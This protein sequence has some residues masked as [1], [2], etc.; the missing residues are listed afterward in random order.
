MRNKIIENTI[1]D[2]IDNTPYSIDFKN[3]FKQFIK[4]KFEDN[5]KEGD[6]K[7]VLGLLEDQT[8]EEDE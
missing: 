3:A 5:A 4:N 7:R 2:V 6:L 8:E 1:D